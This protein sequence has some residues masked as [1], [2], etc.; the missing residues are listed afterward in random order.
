MNKAKLEHIRLQKYCKVEISLFSSHEIIFEQLLNNV[1]I[2]LNLSESKIE[3]N[4]NKKAIIET[5]LNE[6]DKHFNRNEML[7][8]LWLDYSN[9]TK[10]I[11][12]KGISQIK[13]LKSGISHFKFKSKKKQ[14]FIEIDPSNHH[15]KKLKSVLL[16]ITTHETIHDHGFNTAMKSIVHVLK[17]NMKLNKR[18]IKL[19]KTILEQYKSWAKYFI[20]NIDRKTKRLAVFYEKY[21]NNLNFQKLL[22]NKEKSILVKKETLYNIEKKELNSIY[23]SQTNQLKVLKEVLAKKKEF[24]EE[25]KRKFKF[26]IGNM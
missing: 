3:S 15:F 9:K 20:E 13:H 25:E 5:R 26:R 22:L 21:K 16:D 18:Q 17:N 8:K 23:T 2:A 6:I 14:S 1:T 10:I 19:I 24:C 4:N 12:R 7:R 11:L